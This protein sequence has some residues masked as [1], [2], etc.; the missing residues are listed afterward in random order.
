MGEVRFDASNLGYQA[1]VENPDLRKQLERDARRERARA[2]HEL[3]IAPV[4]RLFGRQWTA[5]PTRPSR[6]AAP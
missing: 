6:F 4:L 3:F 2:V 5:G 1:V